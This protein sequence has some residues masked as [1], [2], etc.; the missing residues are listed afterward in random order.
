V[1]LLCLQ[2]LRSVSRK[3]VP[4]V[5]SWCAQPS[6][7]VKFSF[8][9]I[10]RKSKLFMGGICTL[11]FEK[12]DWGFVSFQ[13]CFAV[14]DM[15]CCFGYL[16]WFW[17]SLLLFEYWEVFLGYAYPDWDVFVNTYTYFCML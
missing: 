12:H 11:A 2:N 8:R 7:S 5:P 15:Y 9:T 6:S 16:F 3:T 17:F 1:F 14:L 10:F 13:V 4:A